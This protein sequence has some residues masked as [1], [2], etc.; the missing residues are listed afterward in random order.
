LLF[1]VGFGKLHIRHAGNTESLLANVVAQVP[2]IH[3]CSRF[4]RRHDIPFRLWSG[5]Q[6]SGWGAD[7]VKQV[8]KSCV[9]SFAGKG[10]AYFGRRYRQLY[11]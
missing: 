6:P 2:G 3:L 10:E 7:T 4:P 11:K 5:A 1:E 9:Q 8:L